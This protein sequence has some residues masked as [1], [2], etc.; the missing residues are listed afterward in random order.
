MFTASLAD[1]NKAL[2][3]KVKTDPYMKLL[4]Y[5]Y[6]FIESFSCKKANELALQ[7]REGVNHKIQIKKVN[8]QELKVP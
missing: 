7:C 3:N 2:T 4:K 8:R 5:F 1:I 6:E